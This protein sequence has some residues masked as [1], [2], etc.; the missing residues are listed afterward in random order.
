MTLGTNTAVLCLYRSYCGKE[1]TQG[2]TLALRWQMFSPLILAWEAFWKVTLIAPCVTSE[3]SKFLT[4]RNWTLVRDAI[5]STPG[6]SQPHLGRRSGNFP[7]NRK[8]GQ[9]VTTSS[10]RDM[11]LKCA[12]KWGNDMQNVI[13]IW[14]LFHC[15]RELKKFVTCSPLPHS[16]PL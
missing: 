4:V 8:V 9:S 6:A 7:G 10:R 2:H 13:L 1:Y 11:K 5:R 12:S 15:C 16:T 3:A 14:L